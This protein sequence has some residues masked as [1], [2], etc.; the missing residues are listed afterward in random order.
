M[1]VKSKYLFLKVLFM[2]IQ[3]NKTHNFTCGKMQ[4]KLAE[5]MLRANK[6]YLSGNSSHEILNI[7]HILNVKWL[8]KLYYFKRYFSMWNAFLGNCHKNDS[9]VKN[10]NSNSNNTI[11][12]LTN[13]HQLIPPIVKMLIHQHNRI[14]NIVKTFVHWNWKHQICHHF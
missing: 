8:V 12:I 11:F 6:N 2:K 3:N 4:I 1:N 7:F 13:L 5:T 9:S 14:I 10:I